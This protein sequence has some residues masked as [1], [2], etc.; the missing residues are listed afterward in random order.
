M[1]RLV[2][3]AFMMTMVVVMKTGMRRV[4]TM[5]TMEM[6][7]K[8]QMFLP[9]QQ[10]QRPSRLLPTLHFGYCHSLPMLSDT[11]AH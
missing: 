5:K 2:T 1:R 3:L 7:M 6:A 11:I 8:I 9:L 4:L 10:K